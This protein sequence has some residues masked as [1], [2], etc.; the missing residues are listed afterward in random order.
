MTSPI[1]REIKLNQTSTEL[2]FDAVLVQQITAAIT[3]KLNESRRKGRFGWWSEHLYG[4]AALRGIIQ[5]HLDR[6][7][8]LDV[9]ILAAMLYVKENIL[10]DLPEGELP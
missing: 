10:S 6:D 4:T 5:D 9:C 1:V 3:Q 7:D 8:I 2:L